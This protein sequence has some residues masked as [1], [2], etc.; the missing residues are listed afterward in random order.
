MSKKLAI[1]QPARILSR[2]DGKYY[3]ILLSRLAFRDG[4]FGHFPS[5]YFC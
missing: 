3:I 4:T 1:K 2:E 5:L